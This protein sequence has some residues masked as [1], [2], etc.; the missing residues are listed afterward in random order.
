MVSAI[1][2]SSA[3]ALVQ[4]SGVRPDV[5]IIDYALP[6]D[7]D[8]ADA[9]QT[10]CGALGHVVPTIVLSG[11]LANAAVPWLPGAPLFCVWKPVDSHVLLTVVGTFATLGTLLRT[12]GRP[13]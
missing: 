12:C 3:V 13:A 8:G 1:D 4:E 6:G 10:I 5:L 7:M 9:A 2:G 11:E